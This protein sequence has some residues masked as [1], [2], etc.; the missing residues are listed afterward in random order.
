[1]QADDGLVWSMLYRNPLCKMRI[2][3]F[4]LSDFFC[5]KREEEGESSTCSGPK[6]PMWIIVNW[7]SWSVWQIPSSNWY[8]W[9]DKPFRYHR[10]S[11]SVNRRILCSSGTSYDGFQS[12]KIGKGLAGELRRKKREPDSNWLV[13]RKAAF[14]AIRPE[15]WILPSIHLSSNSWLFIGSF[16]G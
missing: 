15:R 4:L 7:R 11:K 12:Y 10:A 8:N 9:P 6:H 14:F 2:E 3:Q 16:D 5:S 13:D 1:M